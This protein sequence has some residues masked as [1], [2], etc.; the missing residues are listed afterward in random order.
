[1]ANEIV[2]RTVNVFIQSGEA[3]KAYDVLIAKEKKLNDELA[4]TTDPKKIK[5]LQTELSKLSEPIDRA[6]KKLRGELNPS[7]KDVQKTVNDLGNRLKRMSTQ[8]ADYTKILQQYTQAN[9]LL[10]EQKAQINGLAKS[11]SLLGKIFTG[12]FLGNIAA[13]ALGKIK[14]L[15][16]DVI[17]EA[18]EADIKTQ[19]FKNTL[20][21]IGR[22]DAFKR[23]ADAA[24]TLQKKFTFLDNDDIIDVF[25]K[26]IDFGGLT[27]NQ[28]RALTPVIID[29]ATKTGQSLE[30]ASNQIIQAIGGGKIS[31]ELRRFGIDLKNTKDEGGRL[32]VIMTQLKEKVDGAGEA[33]AKTASGG[34]A[35]T[36]QE[37]KDLKEEIGSGLLPVLNSVLRFFVHAAEGA[38]QFAI[39]IANFFEDAFGGAQ[40]AA[41]KAIRDVE[42][43]EKINKQIGREA[44]EKFIGSEKNVIDDE[45]KKLENEIPTLEKAIAAKKRAIKEGFANEN[46]P[47]ELE[48]RRSRLTAFKEELMVLKSLESG[49]KLGSH[50]TQDLDKETDNLIEDQKRLAQE[51]RKI[52]AS[53]IPEGLIKDLAVLD[54]RYDEL[55]KRSKGNAQNLLEIER[56]YQIE[57]IRLIDKYVKD[58]A[59]KSARLDEEQK[60]RILKIAIENNKR[61]S[62]ALIK[63]DPRVEVLNQ[64]FAFFKQLTTSKKQELEN[65]KRNEL[66]SLEDLL[67]A[68]IISQQEYEIAVEAL[69]KKYV[70][71]QLDIDLQHVIA[72]VQ[73]ALNIFTTF[74]Q[75]KTDSENAEL[76]NDRKRNDKKKS[77]L[78]KRLKTGIITQLQ[79]D[80]DL[81]KIEKDQENREKEI[82]KRQFRRQQL[83]DLAQAGI[84]GALAITSTLAAKPGPADVVT[85]GILRAIQVGL[86]IAATAAQIA[87]IASKKPPELAKGGKL[88]GYS[89]Y[90]GGN[91]IIDNSGRKI[92][93][94]EAGEGITNKYTMADRKIYSATGTP[95]Q[96]I[97]RLNSL[98]GGVN[99][100]NGATL[101]PQW[102]II[103][104]QRM[105]FAAMKK[106]YAEG[107]I[108][109]SGPTRQD[110]AN[111]EVLNNLAIVVS[112]MQITMDN[113]QKNGIVAY[114][115]LTQTEKQQA[116]LDAIRND[117]TMK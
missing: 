86:V 60:Q 15:F 72:F 5:Q 10:Q 35:S 111:N 3:Q 8:D 58:S 59:E 66:S 78:E 77:N 42:K 9:I 38:K 76:E 110:S 98:H 47:A 115:L 7:F 1:M 30:E 109:Q 53:L 104:P 93:E 22:S 12:A 63:N 45:I 70:D 31:G 91:A 56:L 68:K 92:A 85:F 94:I 117:A 27:E 62:E 44:A 99:W 114:T 51:L 89:H 57:R 32:N 113:I 96:I 41:N 52:A 69:H 48:Q 25:R 14:N 33:F 95:S 24:D 82:H 65:Q 106:M 6:G 88:G 11:Q 100:E 28:I 73:Q 19:K 108:F 21:T 71:Q 116:R 13:Q 90:E 102:R 29:F 80:R 26:L 17:E 4:K 105:N 87:L 46:D 75:L 23:L 34:I 16:S 49:L 18:I 97:S 81:Q 55:R 107:G 112:N 79:Y 101:M 36:K 67:G 103:S 54:E 40:G 20:D 74:A 39:D 83:A 43:I 64:E 61:L 2:N 50:A 37:F 84:N